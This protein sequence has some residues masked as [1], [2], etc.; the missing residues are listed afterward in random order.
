MAKND[1]INKDIEY[2]ERAIQEIKQDINIKNM[3]E[4]LEGGYGNKMSLEEMGDLNSYIDKVKEILKKMKNHIGQDGYENIMYD[5]KDLSSIFKDY[6]Y[7]HEQNMSK[8]SYVHYEHPSDTEIKNILED[9]NSLNEKINDKLIYIKKIRDK[10]KKSQD[11][12]L[13]A[14]K[15]L[16]DYY[17]EF[18]KTYTDLN[19]ELG[20]SNANNFD[21]LKFF[22]D[23]SKSNS[24]TIH[25]SKMKLKKQIRNF[26]YP[27]SYDIKRLDSN[28]SKAVG[29]FNRLLSF[30]EKRFDMVLD[31][32]KLPRTKKSVLPIRAKGLGPTT[33]FNT[34]KSKVKPVVKKTLRKKN[35]NYDP[36]KAKMNAE[37]RA[38]KPR[39]KQ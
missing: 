33:K 39:K 32:L 30:I 34:E 23:L 13:D 36:K 1:N 31:F 14:H 38:K 11:E 29:L 12:V 37:N 19:N 26:F 21:A 3:K 6:K 27:I 20:S 22:E 18:E 9:I 10:H 4:S 5:V 16:E 24:R 8:H 7:Q 28:Y 15:E 25:A 17:K 35:P 2:I